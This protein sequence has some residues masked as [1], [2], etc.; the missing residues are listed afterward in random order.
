VAAPVRRNCGPPKSQALL[1]SA[2]LILLAA[3]GLAAAS[4]AQSESVQITGPTERP[5]TRQPLTTA[6]WSSNL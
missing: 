6:T 2:C 1:V 4:L 5:R 3:L